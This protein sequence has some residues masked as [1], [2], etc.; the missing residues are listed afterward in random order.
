MEFDDLQSSTLPQIDIKDKN[1][2]L[3]ASK[4]WDVLNRANNPPYLFK[5]ANCIVRLVKIQKGRTQIDR[6]DKNKLR[7]VLARAAIFR[8][9]KNGEFEVDLP[10]VYVIEDM[11]AD[12]NPPLPVLHRIVNTPVFSNNGHLHISPGYSQ[13]TKNYLELY[14]CPEIPQIPPYPTDED[15][16]RAKLLILD[17]LLHDFPFIGESERCN[18]VS[19][20]L[21]PFIRDM[22]IGPLPVYVVEAPSPGTGKTLLVQVLA[23][24]SSGRL[25]EAMSEGR[26]DEEMRKRITAK[27]MK[28]PTHVFIDNVRHQIAYS[29]LA[30]AITANR[31]EDRILGASKTIQLQVTCAWVI[32]G[33]NPSL[34]SE[35]SRRCVRIRMDTGCEQPW[36]RDASA[37]KHPDLLRWV[38]E[39][40]GELIWA[41]LVLIQN[42]ISK[43]M[44]KPVKNTTMGMFEQWCQVMGGILEVNGM[45]GFLDNLDE[46]YTESDMEISLWRSFTEAWWSD[47]GTDAVGVADLY[48]LVLKKDIPIELGSGTE[49]S[50]K[51]RLGIQ[52]SGKRQRQFGP[53]RISFVSQKN[54]SLLWRL[55][56]I[57]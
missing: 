51:I 7:H 40:R 19:L 52:I 3:I 22:I 23:F 34:S 36:L 46:V 48:Q 4:A 12:P 16:S 57:L 6:L 2:P 33:N 21:L 45:H 47:Y 32:T 11:L 53:Y 13:E 10:P 50:Q 35:M 29:S 17:V 55:E 24:P 28:S 49:R 37:F 39:H 42:W 1:L 31:W 44:P 27:L 14:G 38:R 30:S 56:K 8:T 15:I 25:I 18:A 20:F 9:L 26:N 41:G 5:Y 54:H 43:G